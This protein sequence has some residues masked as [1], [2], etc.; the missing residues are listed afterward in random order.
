MAKDYGKSYEYSTLQVVKSIARYKINSKHQVYAMVLFCSKEDFLCYFENKITISE[1][2][3]LRTDLADRFFNGIEFT[4]RDVSKY[5][6]PFSNNN[7]FDASIDE[8]V[9]GPDGCSDGGDD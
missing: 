4:S 2:N 6:L 8:W 3:D 7:N 9:A 5:S 1:Y